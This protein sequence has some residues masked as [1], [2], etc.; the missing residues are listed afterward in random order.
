MKGYVIKKGSEVT[1]W[2]LGSN[3]EAHP[4]ATEEVCRDVTFSE[5]WFDQRQECSCCDSE[6]FVFFHK[7]YYRLTTDVENVTILT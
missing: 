7:F 2:M 6:S 4:V 5:N 3:G 1:G